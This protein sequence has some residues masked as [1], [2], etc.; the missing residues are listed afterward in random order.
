MMKGTLHPPVLYPTAA[1]EQRI[2]EN[3]NTTTKNKAFML[4]YCSP[5]LL[6]E[7]ED[8]QTVDATVDGDR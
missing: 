6:E 1:C 3:R 4:S 8:R 5:V 7:K 2:F